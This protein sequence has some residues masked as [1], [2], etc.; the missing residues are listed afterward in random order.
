MGVCVTGAL[1]ASTNVR[2]ALNLLIA[3][4]RAYLTHEMSLFVVEIL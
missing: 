3:L 4:A 1:S 2:D